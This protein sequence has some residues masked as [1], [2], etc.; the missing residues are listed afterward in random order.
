MEKILFE[1]VKKSYNGKSG[2][3][4][5]CNGTYTLPSHV[6]VEEGN[7]E[8]GYAAYDE[9]DISDRRVKIALSK[10]NKAIDEFGTLV[11]PKTNEYY[12]R[13]TGNWFCYSDSFVGIDI[14]GRATTVYF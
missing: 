11:D 12:D 8:V 5:G 2:C 6:S 7:K 9:S 14:N 3:A 13:E 10:I 4:C 1:N